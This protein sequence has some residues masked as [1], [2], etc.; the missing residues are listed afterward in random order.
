MDLLNKILQL[1]SVYEGD[2]Q[3][4][5]FQTNDPKEAIREAELDISE[6]ADMIMV[7]PGLL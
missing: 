7:K 2:G 3:Q 5:G 4:G 6:G 1:D